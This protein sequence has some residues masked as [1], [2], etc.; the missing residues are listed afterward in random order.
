MH[1]PHGYGCPCSRTVALRTGLVVGTAN[2][3]IRIAPADILVPT[4]PQERHA[5]FLGLYGFSSLLCIRE[6]GVL[7]GLVVVLVCVH[8]QYD[9]IEG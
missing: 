4:V 9:G 1:E 3:V 2:P 8:T 7:V 6:K 5:F